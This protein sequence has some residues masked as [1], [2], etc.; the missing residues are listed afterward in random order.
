ML[1]MIIY[2]KIQF[3]ED[4]NTVEEK[5]KIALAFTSQI[6]QHCKQALGEGRGERF[7]GMFLRKRNKCNKQQGALWVHTQNVC[8]S[9][10]SQG[11]LKFGHIPS[12]QSVCLWNEV[13]K[14]KRTCELQINN[15]LAFSNRTGDRCFGLEVAGEKL[16]PLIPHPTSLLKLN[17]RILKHSCPMPTFSCCPLLNRWNCWESNDGV[18]KDRSWVPTCPWISVL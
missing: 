2:G 5:W 3:G 1:Q 12:L 6:K 16:L 17:Y 18:L 9:K 7:Q 13:R 8:L 15:F 10:Q 11:A 4:D 14:Y